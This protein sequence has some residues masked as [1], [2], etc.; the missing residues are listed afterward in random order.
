M[1]STLIVLLV[2]IR[3]FEQIQD[4]NLRASTALIN[5][6]TE[7]RTSLSDSLYDPDD[8]RFET[9]AWLRI[10]DLR[11]R[12]P[13][14]LALSVDPSKISDLW[15]QIMR[16]KNAFEMIIQQQTV[17]REQ[18]LV[19]VEEW[20]LNFTS[21]VE[22]G[23]ELAVRSM[24]VGDIL[25]ACLRVKTF[26]EN[27]E[28]VDGFMRFLNDSRAVSDGPFGPLYRPDD[29]GSA[30]LFPEFLRLS[31][32]GISQSILDRISRETE[33]LGRLKD[34]VTQHW[35]YFQ[36]RRDRLRKDMEN[37]IIAPFH[38]REK[39]NEFVSGFQFISG[40]TVD[41]MMRYRDK[42]VRAF[43]ALYDVWSDRFAIWGFV[44]F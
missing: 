25:E 3:G 15:A 39:I 21:L 8:D 41:Q 16:G 36:S 9:S 4:E 35:Q 22:T 19:Q 23:D 6:L 30:V 38:R 1:K 5:A 40:C 13:K 32:N 17:G 31:K 10:K 44:T 42:S 12:L 43:E 37:Q 33:S 28:L 26:L 29:I 11:K 34:C 18:L 27:S 2:G 20:K 7:I 14:Q 24:S